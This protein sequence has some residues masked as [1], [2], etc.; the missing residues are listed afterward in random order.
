MCCIFALYFANF[1]A[2]FEI[3]IPTPVHFFLSFNIEIIMHPDP[4]PISSI[5]F[6]E[7]ILISLKTCS[8][9][10]SESGLGINTLLLTLNFFFQ[11]Y[12]LN[13]FP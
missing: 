5:F 12:Q 13:L 3:S 4:V 8:T 6:L 10:V 9:N 2:F 7:L 1:N 11:N